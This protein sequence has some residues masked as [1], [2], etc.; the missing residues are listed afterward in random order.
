M[1]DKNKNVINKCCAVTD[2]NK[3]CNK[4]TI[5]SSYHC[6]EHYNKAKELYIK[7]KKICSTAYNLNLNNL[8]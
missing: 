4:Q 3:R 2:D 7:Y 1:E 5:Y 8:F 6:S